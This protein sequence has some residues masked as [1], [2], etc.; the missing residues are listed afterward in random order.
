MHKKMHTDNHNA[1]FWE[2]WLRRGT[3][4]KGWQNCY[5]AM[6]SWE[7]N[8]RLWSEHATICKSNLNFKKIL[9]A[10]TG[11]KLL[12]VSNGQHEALCLD[13]LSYKPLQREFQPHP[14]LGPRRFSW[15]TQ[16][17][18]ETSSL[19]RSLWHPPGKSK[20]ERQVLLPMW[21]SWNS[22]RSLRRV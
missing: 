6:H 12:L 1:C 15:T 22:H 3:N 14:D 16:L 13:G 8:S 7:L 19:R 21:T 20:D 11:P 2:R 4:F 17:P 5:V 18:A 9:K 10:C